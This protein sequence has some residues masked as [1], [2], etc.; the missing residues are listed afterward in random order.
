ML[1]ETDE[2]IANPEV[3]AL[4]ARLEKLGFENRRDDCS[5]TIERFCL[6]ERFDWLVI[7]IPESRLPAKFALKAGK[8]AI[9]LL[10]NANKPTTS[11]SRTTAKENSVPAKDSG[12]IRLLGTLVFHRVSEECSQNCLFFFGIADDVAYRN[13]LGPK[14]TIS[15]E[16]QTNDEWDDE[17]VAIESIYGDENEERR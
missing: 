16:K 5:E 1:H 14:F 12:D 6:R 10:N 9:V 7:N 15:L 4:T 3:E 11:S 17:I 13:R 8:H 2:E